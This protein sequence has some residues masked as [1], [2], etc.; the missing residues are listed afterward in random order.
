MSEKEKEKLEELEKQYIE[1][2]EADMNK[3]ASK[4]KTKI[5][6]I[7]D[8]IELQELRKLKDLKYENDKYKQFIKHRGLE[9]EFNRFEIKKWSWESYE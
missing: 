7:K 9:A 6:K 1:Y 4:I 2:L 3:E 5:N 8:K